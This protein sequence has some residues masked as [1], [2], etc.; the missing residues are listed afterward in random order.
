MLS[1][2]GETFPTVAVYFLDVIVV[3]IFAGLTWEVGTATGKRPPG[4]A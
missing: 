1:I 3:K 2:L 4:P